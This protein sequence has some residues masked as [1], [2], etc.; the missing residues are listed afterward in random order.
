MKCQNFSFTI[1]NIKHGVCVVS[2][3]W[4]DWSFMGAILCVTVRDN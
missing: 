1:G 4:D 2:I 3:G